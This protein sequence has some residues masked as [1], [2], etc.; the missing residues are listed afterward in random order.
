MFMLGDAMSIFARSTQAPSSNSPRRICSNRSRFS[1]TERSRY[2]LF[3]PGS[4][5]VPRYA[6]VSSA[7]RSTDI[8]LP[9]RDQLDGKLVQPIEV[10]GG[11]EEVGAPVETQPVHVLLD[12]LDVLDVLLGR[13]RVVEAQVAD[14][15]ELARDAEV[16]ADRFGVA[17]VQVAVRLRRKTGAHRPVLAALQVV[18]DYLADEVGSRRGTR[19]LSFGLIIH[20]RRFS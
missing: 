12:R 15:A 7:V 10:V 13:V 9:F 17:D 2:G 1:S 16:E 20:R 3:L 5:S 14:A 11:V 6:R 8:R 18:D 19:Y 4:V